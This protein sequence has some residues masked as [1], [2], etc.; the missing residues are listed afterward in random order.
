MSVSKR[1][2]ISFLVIT[3]LVT[4]LL[5]LPSVLNSNGYTIHPVFLITSMMASFTPSVFGLVYLKKTY[6]NE[7]KSHLKELLKLNFNKL[8]FLWITLFFLVVAFVPY[9]LFGTESTPVIYMWPLIFLQILVIGGALGEE[10]GWRAFAY[11]ALKNFLNPLYAT[12][13]LGVIW[14]LWHLPL[15]FM[16]GT[17]QSNLPMWQ[18]MLQNTLIAF[19]YTWV[20]E[21]VSGSIVLMI[22]L[23]AVANTASAIFPYWQSNVG[24]WT[25]FGM[26]LVSVLFMYIKYPLK[27]NHI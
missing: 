10:F 3:V 17:V 24:R 15:F 9:I 16:E 4:W 2:V 21:R 27:K 25:G 5:W 18:F 1:S 12:L 8:W 6:K 11:P 13:L 26:L 14:S 22:F 7:F 20:Y 23:H 19:I